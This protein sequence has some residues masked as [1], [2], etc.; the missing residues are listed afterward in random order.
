MQKFIE[1]RLDTTLIIFKS[2]LQ[3][4]FKPDT[5]NSKPGWITWG[6]LIGL[7]FAGIL[8]WGNF[9]HW[10]GINFEVGDW[11]EI[12]GPRLAFL[13]DAVRSGELP[14]HISNPSTLGGI[15]DRFLSIP[16][17]ILSPQVL[18]LRFL[19]IGRFVFVDVSLLYTIGFLG[20]LWLRRRFSLSCFTF[21]ILFLLFNFN[22]HI[23]AHFSAGHVTWGGYFLFPWFAILVINLIEGERS[24]G[25]V[26]KTSILLFAIFLQGSFHQYVW[27]L[28]FLGF[29]ALSNRKNFLP[30]LGTIVFS[31]LVSMAR[32]LPPALLV[33]S[34]DNQYVGGYLSISDIWTSMVTILDPHL[35]V[36]GP[37]TNQIVKV[38]ELTLF[39]GLIGGIFLLYFGI[40]K[41]F[42]GDN[43]LILYK[44][45]AIP[46]F[47][48]FILSF[49]SIYRLVRLVP[50]P[51][52]AGERVSSRIISLPFVFILI[53]AAIQLQ[54]WLDQPNKD[55]ALFRLGALALLLIACHD[56][57]E[58]YVNWIPAAVGNNIIFPKFVSSQ[59]FVTN[60][61]DPVY[62]TA[63]EVGILVSFLSLFLVIVL[64][65]RP[66]KQSLIT[67]ARVQ[68]YP[69]SSGVKG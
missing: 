3:H 7:F 20:L 58:N 42:K 6:W 10:G 38:W 2:W 40:Y 64:A 69:D 25:W 1:A 17:E 55:R 11:L 43:G 37:L 45:L 18:L 32:I 14:L 65:L 62:I 36:G 51:L 34:F 22:G 28:L 31:I 54:R 21:T 24:W 16:D 53:L 61:A 9:L 67:P 56:L 4:F 41:W 13:R 33:G 47:G 39:T 35:K 15:T 68:V 59:W 12:S 57:W 5:N 29:M 63:I 66:P 23:L 30:V 26:A 46:V 60:H 48:T 49:D 8:L 19:S 52:L 50:I 27:A 44:E